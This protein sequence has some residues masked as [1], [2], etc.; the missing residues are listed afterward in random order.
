MSRGW[1][2]EQPGFW[3][4]EF[5]AQLCALLLCGLGQAMKSQLPH[6]VAVILPTLPASL[7][8]LGPTG[9]L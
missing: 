4:P 3:S 2:R 5:H 1:F 6:L 7:P 9:E 8:G